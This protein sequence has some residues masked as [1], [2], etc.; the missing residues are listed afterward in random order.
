MTSPSD[1]IRTEEKRAKWYE[2]LLVEWAAL[3]MDDRQFSAF[4]S[5][6][7]F[8]IDENLRVVRK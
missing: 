4:L 8:V 5:K 7:G 3:V 2:R 6:Y 1:V